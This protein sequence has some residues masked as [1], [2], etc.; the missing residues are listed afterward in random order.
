MLID[1]NI[2]G[3]FLFCIF[4]EKYLFPVIKCDFSDKN[5]EK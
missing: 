5:C 4:N 1:K 3:T 2:E